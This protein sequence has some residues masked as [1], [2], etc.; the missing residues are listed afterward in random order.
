MRGGRPKV[1]KLME[2]VG[3]FDLD[4]LSDGLAAGT[5]CGNQNKL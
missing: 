1:P 2:T 5:G 3:Q 4:T